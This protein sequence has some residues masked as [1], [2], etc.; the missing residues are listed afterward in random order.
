M[1]PAPDA[2]L[3]KIIW[4]TAAGTAAGAL[5]GTRALSFDPLSGSVRTAHEWR[6]GLVYGAIGGVLS[7]ALTTRLLEG[8]EPDAPHRFFLDRW[9]TPLLAGMITV[10]VLDFTST[11][12]FRDR[13]KSEWLLTNAVV[14]HRPAFVA[15]EAAAAAAGIGLIYLFHRSGHHRLERWIEAG[16]ISLGTAS[17]IANYRYPHTGHGLFGN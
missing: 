7:A 5:I 1:A 11:R 15:T 17:A 6:A 16:Y 10:H 3:K 13:G 8:P 14:D 2:A 9:N 4:A 12:Y